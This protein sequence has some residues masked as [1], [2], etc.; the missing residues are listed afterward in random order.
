[1]DVRVR[2]ARHGPRQ[3]LAPLRDAGFDL[4]GVESVYDAEES[5]RARALDVLLVRRAAAR[6]VEAFVEGSREE[7]PERSPPPGLPAPAPQSGPPW[8]SV[9]VVGCEDSP[10][11]R[12]CLRAV[13][14]QARALGAELVL[15][16]NTSA[17][18]VPREARE[19]L[20]DWCDVVCFEPRVG[21]T[22]ALHHGIDRCRGEVV[23]FTDDDALPEPGWL[24]AITAPLLRKDRPP[25]V[26][27]CGGPVQPA[28]RARVPRWY[29]KA[30]EG[31][32]THY[33]GPRHD[34]GPE[35]V[36]YPP[37]SQR[38]WPSAPLGANCAYRR[39][40]FAR[41]RYAADLGPNRE[42]GGRGGEDFELAFRL[43]LD[44]YRLRYRPEARVR[45]PVTRERMSL[46]FALRAARSN[47]L[48]CVRFQHKLGLPVPALAETRRLIRALEE[49]L[50]RASG[51]GRARRRVLAVQLERL[52]GQAA[53]LD[54][55]GA[56]A[57]RDIERG[58]PP[59]TEARAPGDSRAPAARPARNR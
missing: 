11:L 57:R 5:L 26:V 47:G 18:S 29:R 42:T 27:G 9:L 1:V 40:V 37:P 43:L 17:Q 14:R 12:A 33:L 55:I 16:L 39:E 32:S 6:E 20:A 2:V 48:E 35:P 59:A 21:K 46:D 23:A 22:H 3:A 38:P 30:V 24:E 51:G 41:Y 50:D 34:L 49:R 58:A 4:A 52:R 8:I 36:D 13:S 7:L 45:H 15:V 19:R 56:A 25:E 44:G 28:Y 31:Q 10:A 53:E 54:R